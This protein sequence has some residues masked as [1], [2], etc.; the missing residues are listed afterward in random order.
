M[1]RGL[2]VHRDGT[3][4]SRFNRKVGADTGKGYLQVTVRE[5]GGKEYEYAHRL[6]WN[7]FVGDIPEG[8]ELD[9][10]DGNKSNN[11]LDNLRLCTN[12]LN[13][14]YNKR[15]GVSYSKRDGRWMSRV[16]AQ[17]K[18]H[19]LGCYDTEEEAIE[20]YELAKLELIDTLEAQM[21]KEYNLLN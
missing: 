12:S 10:I 20:I 2:T 3:I 13:Q 9:H 6:V 19:F 8:L 17:G 18:S 11:N 21:R 15:K 1:Y 14:L 7:A 16:Q 5:N 4:M